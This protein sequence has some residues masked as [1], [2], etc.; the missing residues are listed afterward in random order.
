M[1]VSHA[2]RTGGAVD[3]KFRGPGVVAGPAGTVTDKLI[4]AFFS[5]LTKNNF[6]DRP[7]RDYIA[8]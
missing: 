2:V 5:A 1:L 7:G 4:K 6:V 3:G 8:I